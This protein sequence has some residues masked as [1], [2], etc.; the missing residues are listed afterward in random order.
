MSTKIEG[1]VDLDYAG[2]LD[3]KKFLTRY[4]FTIYGGGVN[5]KGNLQPVVALSITKAEYIAVTEAIKGA[6]WL[7]V[8][9]IELGIEHDQNLVFYDNQSAIC[10][11]KSSILW[12][13]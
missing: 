13:D 11:A 6:I 12:K 7:K 5:W 4:V 3:T 8:I 9:I 1:F 2:S 10:L